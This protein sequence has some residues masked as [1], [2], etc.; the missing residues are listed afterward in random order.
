MRRV[1]SIQGKVSPESPGTG[2]G[3]AGGAAGA[4]RC[5]GTRMTP[6]GGAA[7]AGVTFT[8]TFMLMLRL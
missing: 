7:G 6:A 3:A 2:G 1:V 8:L 5:A 4:G